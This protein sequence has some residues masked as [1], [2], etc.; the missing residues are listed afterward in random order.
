MK[1]S[2]AMTFVTEHARTRPVASVANFS[3]RNAS[4]DRL[5]DERQASRLGPSE[6]VE[7]HGSRRQRPVDLQRETGKLPDRGV[8]PDGPGQTVESERRPARLHGLAAA[9]VAFPER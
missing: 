7:E 8:R 2:P 1:A 9:E 4:T 3:R 6:T 5:A